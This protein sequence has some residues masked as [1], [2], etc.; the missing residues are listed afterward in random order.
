MTSLDAVAF[1]FGFFLLVQVILIGFWFWVCRTM[2]RAA[3]VNHDIIV[4]GLKRWKRNAEKER[5][6]YEMKE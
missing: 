1:L 4:K 2:V 5:L 6:F 3:R